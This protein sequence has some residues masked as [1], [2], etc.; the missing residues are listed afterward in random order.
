MGL[1]AT[2]GT[3]TA[4][5]HGDHRRSRA[6]GAGAASR[7]RSRFCNAILPR[8]YQTAQGQHESG[9]RSDVGRRRVPWWREIRV[10]LRPRRLPR[11]SETGG[12]GRSGG[13]TLTCPKPHCG[14]E[15]AKTRSPYAPGDG[16]TVFRIYKCK[17]CGCEFRTK[18]IFLSIV[19]EPP[20]EKVLS[21]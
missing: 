14:G 5:P 7:F 3:L 10:H 6:S 20:A 2:D 12:A 1:Y 4:H 15:A 9:R 18:E 21:V 13:S 8:G 19:R 11:A 16:Q 17:D